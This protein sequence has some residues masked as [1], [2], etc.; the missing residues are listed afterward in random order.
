ML[1]L[2][3]AG[4]GTVNPAVPH[5]NAPANAQWALAEWFTC[6]G[7]PANIEPFANPNYPC[8]GSPPCFPCDPACPGN[9]DPDGGT[10]PEVCCDFNGDIRSVK[11]SI[12]DCYGEEVDTSECSSS[13]SSSCIPCTTDEDCLVIYNE[14]CRQGCCQTVSS[15]T[16]SAV[17]FD[18]DLFKTLLSEIQKTLDITE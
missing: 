4:G 17:G 15:S 10:G 2:I 7:C 6:A 14:E 18:T 8:A 5:F 9:S 12:C 3:G 11:K 16:S 13:S 1:S